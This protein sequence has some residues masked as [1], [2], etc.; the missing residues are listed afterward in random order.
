VVALDDDD[1]PSDPAGSAPATTAS[2]AFFRRAT[3]VVGS[4]ALPFAFVMLCVVAFMMPSVIAGV[5]RA[6]GGD[7]EAQPTT[8]ATI[9]KSEAFIASVGSRR[10]LMNPKLGT[11][12]VR[13]IHVT[14]HGLVKIPHE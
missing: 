14:L 4:S 10:F 11:P 1:A 12:V 8:S 7:V 9:E 13:T 6:G 3:S 2:P 5:V